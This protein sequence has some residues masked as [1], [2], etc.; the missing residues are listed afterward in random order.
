M[1]K[2]TGHVGQLDMINWIWFLKKLCSWQWWSQ[3][4]KG[5][6]SLKIQLSQV[7]SSLSWKL[8]IPLGPWFSFQILAKKTKSIG[9][10]HQRKDH[11]K[12]NGVNPSHASL[13][14]WINQQL[15]L[16]STEYLGDILKLKFVS[17]KWGWLHSHSQPGS[18]LNDDG[19]LHFLRNRS[20]KDQVGHMAP[21]NPN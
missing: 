14:Q 15:V 8:Q 21:T 7:S 5:M 12:V 3:R 16:R 17:G 4:E 2:T 9:S 10:K 11:A 13:Q 18:N 6:L 1:C 19:I 20:I